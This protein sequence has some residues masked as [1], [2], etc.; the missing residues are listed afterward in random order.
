MP[1]IN[2]SQFNIKGKDSNTF[3]RV[4]ISTPQKTLKSFGQLA[5]VA[6]IESPEEKEIKDQVKTKIQDLIDLAVNNLYSKSQDN[7]S[8][9][10]NFEKL[11]QQLNNWLQAEKEFF[12]KIKDLNLTIINTYQKNIFLSQIGNI[13]VY[14]KSNNDL[15]EISQRN[16]K[17]KFSNVISGAL[18][19]EN[20]LLVTSKNLFDYFSDKKIIQLFNN[21]KTKEIIQNIKN[22][23]PET[24]ENENITGI[25]MDRDEKQKSEKE[26][27]HKEM[28]IQKTEKQVK[29]KE[30]KN[31]QDIKEEKDN[32]VKK[33]EKK[34]EKETEKEHPTKQE[35]IEKPS[36]KK[37]KPSQKKSFQNKI[38]TSKIKD[39]PKIN[40]KKTKKPHFIALIVIIICAVLF[41][42]SII[43]LSN[44]KAKQA[45]QEKYNT[46]IEQIES[47]KSELTAALISEDQ[48]AT[49][50]LEEMRSLLKELP[51]NTKE[52]KDAY[53]TYLSSYKNA[54]YRIH[55]ITPIESPKL[56]FEVSSLSENAKAGDLAKIGNN[57]YVLNSNNNNIYR[58]NTKNQQSLTI[59]SS[60]TNVGLLTEISKMDN[61][62]LIGFT[63]NKVATF[64]IVD[65]ILEPLTLETEHQQN[66]EKI[67]AY[68]NKIYT[69][70]PLNNQIYKYSKSIDS[71]SKET[72]WIKD[73]TNIENGYDF[74]IDGSIYVLLK[75][76]NI[77]KLYTGEKADFNNPQFSPPISL[78]AKIKTNYDMSYIYI[79][80]PPS[81]RLI[82]LS[83]QGNIIEQYASHNFGEIKD[84]VISDNENTVWI[85]SDDKIY[86]IEI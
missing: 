53:N 73:S 56:V 25:I 39:M 59:N 10:Q 63:G 55:D 38:K 45:E 8:Q 58:Y 67:I 1:L 33:E 41:M 40:I 69:L 64:N 18:E 68:N 3:S 24:S 54:Y 61:D 70:E 4:H 66:I 20:N 23:L 9:E 28:P 22:L 74:T 11:L 52:Q 84:F 6:F 2:F 62:N 78:Q 77:I 48:A 71:F 30:E 75:A 65:N 36:P 34:E 15:T 51:T 43:V 7:L 79:L 19:K 50:T 21:Q 44:K 37:I 57:L 17:I 13:G 14:F 81:K 32:K 35:K 49:G 80:D 85:L 72:P 29:E 16:K 27:N 31:N 86:E 26:T 82:K 76:G 42:A 12:N 83:K 47:K 46:L 5:I 60:S